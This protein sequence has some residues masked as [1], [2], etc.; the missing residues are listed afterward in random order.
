M[1]CTFNAEDDLEMINVDSLELEMEVDVGQD[2]ESNDGDISNA[3]DDLE[4]EN[5]TDDVPGDDEGD[6]TLQRRE[7]GQYVVVKISLII[8][9]RR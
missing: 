1:A 6:T 4:D 3:I 2:S 5:N 7:R 9:G 8:L